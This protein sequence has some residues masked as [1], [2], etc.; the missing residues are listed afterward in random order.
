MPTRL[1]GAPNPMVLVIPSDFER[2]LIAR[3][4]AAGACEAT[5]DE[6]NDYVEASLGVDRFSTAVTA[7][8]LPD[9]QAL[10]LS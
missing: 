6:A 10:N 1:P 2:G 5:K 8:T 9:S 4:A 3:L 7:T